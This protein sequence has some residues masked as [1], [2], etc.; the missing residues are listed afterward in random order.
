MIG[1]LYG[2]TVLTHLVSYYDRAKPVKGNKTY[3]SFHRDY[4]PQKP[5]TLGPVCGGDNTDRGLLG[6]HLSAISLGFMSH[7]IATR[8]VSWSVDDYC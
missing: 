3:L 7:A 1:S 6:A 2:T 8:N 5:V 4:G